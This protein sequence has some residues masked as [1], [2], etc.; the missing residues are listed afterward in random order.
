MIKLTGQESSI[1][2]FLAQ[3]PAHFDQFKGSLSEGALSIAKYL[4][5]D[6]NASLD[7][8]I[9]GDVIR[10]WVKECIK[11]ESQNGH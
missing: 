7:A 4:T 9:T 10:L 3:Y 8:R 5:G 1:L 6:E 11:R 2:V